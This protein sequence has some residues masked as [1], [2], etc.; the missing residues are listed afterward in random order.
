[1][2][3]DNFF[4][5][6]NYKMPE[7]SN[8]MKF[9]EGENVFRVL[10]SAIIGYEYFNNENKPV[11]SKEPF[12]TLPSDIKKDGTIKH[13]W[14]FVVYNE[15]AKRIQILEL[16]QKSIMATMQAYIKNPKWGDPKSYDFI[17][18]RTGSGMDTEYATTVNPKAPVEEKVTEQ[19]KKLNIDLTLLF[20]NEDPFKNN[21]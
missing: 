17:V 7:T 14:A 11:R 21:A 19:F 9:K 13:F 20:V 3:N 15:D 18:T 1:M 4:G 16:T 12:D 5:D 6:A 2:N 10:S 8:Y